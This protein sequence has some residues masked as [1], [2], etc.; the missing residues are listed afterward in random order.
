MRRAVIL[1]DTRGHHHFGCYRVMETIEQKLASRGFDVSARSLVRQRWWD[2]PSFL[3]QMRKS[4]LIVI[5][6]E[7]TL[8]HGSRHGLS[9]LKV[10]EHPARRSTPIALVNAL[11]QDN[12]PEWKRFIDRI[13]YLNTRDSWSARELEQLSRRKVRST[14]DFS[15][16]GTELL[17]SHSQQR[18]QLALGDSVRRDAN[19]ALVRLSRKTPNSIFLPIVRTMKSSKPQYGRVRYALREAYI[20][21]HTFLFRQSL[22]NAVFC[23]D[24]K[25]YCNVL[26]KSY[27]HVTG[28]FHGVCLSITTNTPFIGISSNSWKIEALLDDIGLDRKRLMTP[29]QIHV[30]ME[31]PGRM[32]FTDKEQELLQ[33]ALA[34]AQVET[35]QVFGEILSLVVGRSQELN[36]NGKAALSENTTG[37]VQKLVFHEKGDP[38]TLRVPGSA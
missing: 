18:E 17:S 27:L 32:T 29:E 6:G 30:A 1:N 19:S 12:P 10:A 20:H 4:D 22:N 38:K 24:H 2:N 31:E 36:E 3:E 33:G 35:D 7:G 23:K 13:D 11:Y 16:A 15:L 34:R 37:C 14:L 8:H 28:R 21:S 25:E 9:L 5:N 26:Q